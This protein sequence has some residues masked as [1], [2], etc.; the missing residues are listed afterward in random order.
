MGSNRDEGAMFLDLPKN[1]SKAQFEEFATGWADAETTRAIERLYP[2][3][4][5]PYASAD[6]T[7]HWWAMNR[8]WG[9]LYMAC[10][11]NFAAS[12]MHSY[13]NNQ[14][15]AYWFGRR[16]KDDVT[17]VHGGEIPYVFNYYAELDPHG[18]ALALQVVGYWK[19]MAQTSS[20]HMPEG[21]VAWPRWS[22]S[23]GANGT[24]LRFDGE[25]HQPAT[26]VAQPGSDEPHRVEVCKFW[27]AFLMEK[28]TTQCVPPGNTWH[29]AC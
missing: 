9:D 3:S 14:V 6:R 2:A 23:G 20:P 29:P 1:A 11:V 4:L 8:A 25:G 10:P 17:L 12:S 18:Q 19:S 21:P 15:Y 13:G 26:I 7:A 24:F 27:R 5:Y 22:S 16:N 28:I